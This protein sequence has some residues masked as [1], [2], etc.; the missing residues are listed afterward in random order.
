MNKLFYIIIIFFIFTFSARSSEIIQGS[1][2]CKVTDQQITRIEEGIVNKYVGYSDGYKIND[3]FTFRYEISLKK[4]RLR[5][6]HFSKGNEH[7]TLKQQIGL[8]FRGGGRRA[9]LRSTRGVFRA[10][11]D[12]GNRHRPA[13]AV[14]A[15]GRDPASRRLSFSLLVGS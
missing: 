5:G 8:F 10:A 1:M 9:F 2:D 11:R 13:V 7:L 12:P 6:V 15:R 3:K 14:A 4:N